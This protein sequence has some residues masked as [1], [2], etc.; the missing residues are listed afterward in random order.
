[1]KRDT[2][3]DAMDKTEEDIITTIPENSFRNVRVRSKG[4][5]KLYKGHELIGV[6]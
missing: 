5:A 3:P 6:V 4:A 2:T 1:L